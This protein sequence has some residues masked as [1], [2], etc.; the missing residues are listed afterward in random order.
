MHPAHEAFGRDLEPTMVRQVAGLVGPDGRPLT[1]PAGPGA[2]PGSLGA[3]WFPPGEP[4]QPAAPRGEAYG[5]AFD[6]PTGWNL[7][8][9]PRKGEAYGFPL[10]RRLAGFDLVAL[11]IETRKDQMAELTGTVQPRKEPKEPFRRPIDDRCRTAM[12]FFRKPD[13]VNYFD[14]WLRKLLDDQLVI[15][16]PTLVRRDDRAGRFWAAEPIDGA[17]IHRLIDKSGRTPAPP[18]PAYQQVLK[19]IPAV[20]YTAEELIYAPR[21]PRTWKLYGFSPVEQIILTVN[22][23]MRRTTAQLQ[24]YTEGNVPEALIGLP[25]SWS[26]EQIRG[27]QDYWD[28]LM[29]N[30]AIRRRAK[31]VPGQFAFQPT[32]GDA[33]LMD[34]YDEWLVRIICYAFSLPP[35]PFVKVMNRATAET[36]Y[37]AALREGLS[38]IMKWAKNVLDDII[39]TWLGWPDLEWVWDDSRDLD[40][41]EQVQVDRAEMERG[42]RGLDDLR[43]ARG[44]DPV[45]LKPVVFGV[46]PLGFMSVEQM[47]QAIDQGLTMPQPPPMLGPEGMPLAPGQDPL[48]GAPP[49]LL[50]QLGIDPA[51]AQQGAPPEQD[52]GEL[53]EEPEPAA[54][55]PAPAPGGMAPQAKLA[56]RAAAAMPGGDPRGLVRDML[57]HAGRKMGRAR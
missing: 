46:G 38:P 3:G 21:N 55:E 10:L 54:P 30:P 15:D 56:P 2:Q 22:I 18:M 45:G 16:A 25:E 23:A 42:I 40:P 27:F 47:V 43:A 17:T 35:L 1:M 6:Y 8:Y 31:F 29:S 44:L 9:A 53:E 48:A 36:S 51:T 7:T 19:G 11:A 34:Q 33:Q 50:A 20:D 26:T 5:R 13:Q 32:R 12:R 41:T 57:R 49:E 37:D 52:E 28:Q 39:T 4:Q 14:T 24:H